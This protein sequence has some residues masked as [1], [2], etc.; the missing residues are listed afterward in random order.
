MADKTITCVQCGHNFV[1][2]ENEQNFYREKGLANEP[3]KCPECRAAAKKQRSGA[4]SFK[5]EMY[6]TVCASCGK[7]A[8]VPFVPSSDKPVY[9]KEC[10]MSKR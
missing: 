4:R 2:T 1:F 3:K 7:E 9:C 6:T 5:K 10:Y 8:K